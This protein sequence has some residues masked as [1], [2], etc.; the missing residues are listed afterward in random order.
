ML[1]SWQF[2]SLR[3]SLSVLQHNVR[4]VVDAQ[5]WMKR[6]VKIP[7]SHTVT[8]RFFGFNLNRIDICEASACVIP[9][10]V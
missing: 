6:A 7:I 9:W 5:S 1:V 8:I 4:R 2:T 10:Y 3:V